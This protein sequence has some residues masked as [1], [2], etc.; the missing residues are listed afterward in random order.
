M[1][2]F[3]ELSY[4]DYVLYFL[5]LGIPL[6]LLSGPFL[7]DLSVSIVAIVFLFKLR[8]QNLKKYFNNKFFIFFF[9]LSIYSW[10]FLLYYQI[11]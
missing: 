1:M 8:T 2:S 10:Y 4:S 9:L 11:T 7:P 5:I 3:K 6:T